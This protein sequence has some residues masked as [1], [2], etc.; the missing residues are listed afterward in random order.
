MSEIVL[1]TH[2][3]GQ[4]F[5][6]GPQAI[7]VLKDVS[8]QVMRGERVAI[9]GRSGS[10]KTTLLHLLGGLELPSSGRVELMGNDLA[11]MSE[12]ERSKL[13]NQHIGFVYQL[14]HL[15]PEFTALENV[16]LP[17]VIGGM[18][19]KLARKKAH[20]LLTRVGLSERVEHKP[21][22]L[23]GGERQRVALARALVCDPALVLADEPTGNLDRDTAESIHQLIVELNETLGISFIIV[24]HEERLASLAHR[25]LSMSSGSLV[26]LDQAQ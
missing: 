14:H 3:L 7:T 24:T 15:L 8:F 9:V 26:E 17:A 4:Q 20:E 5:S 11:S 1:A 22:E 12:A 2:D 16:S 19:P 6:E 13:R 25:R 21:S 18:S 23:S 10:G